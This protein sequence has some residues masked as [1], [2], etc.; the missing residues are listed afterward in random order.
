MATHLLTS[1][2]SLRLLRLPLIVLAVC[3]CLSGGGCMSKKDRAQ[4]FYPQ[5]ATNRAATATAMAAA[6]RN[7][8]IKLDD[9]LDMAFD[10]LEND[11][12][13][14]S[15]AFAGAVLDFAA[16]IERELPQQPEYFILW[17]RIGGLAGHSATTAY[18]LGDFP[19]ARSLVLAGPRKWQTDKYW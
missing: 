4:L 12:D 17:M 13:A 10:H 2:S 7:Q 16:E 8:E 5:A 1:F 18:N 19:A 14:A 6:W 15:I 9:C 3:C 11:S